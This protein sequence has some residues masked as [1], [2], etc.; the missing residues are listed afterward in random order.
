MSAFTIYHNPRCSKSRETL[1][2]LQENGV[3]PTVVEYLKTP[4]SAATVIALSKGLGVPVSAFLRNKEDEY[5][6]LNLK[7]F[8]GSDEALAE[9][10][11]QHPKILERPIV[12]RESD[13]HARIGRPPEAVL[14][15]L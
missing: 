9:I 10:V 12:V 13:Q 8:T 15:L 14:E 2:L 1:K 3:Q 6:A 7:S 4:P 11:S 5:K